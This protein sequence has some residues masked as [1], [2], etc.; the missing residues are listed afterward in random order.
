MAAGKDFKY[1]YEDEVW[2]LNRKV[3]K[4][5]SSIYYYSHRIPEAGSVCFWASQIGIW[6]R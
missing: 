6:P 2:R 1:F 5:K 3:A 4:Y